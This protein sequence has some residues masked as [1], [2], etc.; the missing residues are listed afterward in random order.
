[1]CP[2]TL[3]LNAGRTCVRVLHRCNGWNA[4]APDIPGFFGFLPLSFPGSQKA[5]GQPLRAGLSA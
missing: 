1:M 5:K 4:A 3:S 2:A